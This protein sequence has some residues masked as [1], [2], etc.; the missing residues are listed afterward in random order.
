M[1]AAPIFYKETET[2]SKESETKDEMLQEAAS[3]ESESKKKNI[4]NVI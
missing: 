2:E 4:K 1:D 3:Y